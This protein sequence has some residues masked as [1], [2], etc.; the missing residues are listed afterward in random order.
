MNQDLTNILH[1][2]SY[3][4]DDT[5]RIIAA[6]DGR[7]VLQVRLPLGIEQYEL[8]GRPDGRTPFG[9]ENFLDEVE[10]RLSEYGEHFGSEDGFVLDHESSVMLQSEGVLFYYRYLL[11][12][13]MNDFARV[14]R[15]TEHNL[16]ICDL[17][18]RY[19]EKEEDRRTVLQYRP[20][21]I[22]M[23]AMAR[24]M[25]NVHGERRDVALGII[26]EAV[27]AIEGLSEVDTP[28]FQFEK[29]R[30]LNYLRSAV[31]QIS[32]GL[33]VEEVG[34]ET[35]EE[36]SRTRLERAL[37]EAIQEED[38]ERAAEIR[39]EIRGLT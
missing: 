19:A 22:R 24:A 23:N 36:G 28:A 21:I 16:R 38:Y 29:I 7:R 18:E 6:E 27:D 37:A 20:Y 32:S 3:D 1:N 33:V 13:Q 35:V 4:P 34:D 2:W 11:L 8:D 39:D 25:I 17:L 5:T 31:E 12:F 26:Q 9:R 14:R 30:S 10:N 15:D